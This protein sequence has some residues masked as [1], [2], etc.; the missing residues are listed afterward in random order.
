MI[1]RNEEKNLEECLAPVA[2]LF[3][4][5]V[6]IDTGSQDATKEIAAR[7]TQ[8]IFDFPWCDDFS[9]ARNES[10]ERSSGDWIFWLDADDRVRP[11]NA[12]RLEALLLSLEDRRRA[13]FMDTVVLGPY[14]SEAPQLLSHPRLF[15]RHPELRW[16]NRVH[17]QVRAEME[18]LGYEAVWSDIQIDHVGYED[19]LV[20]QR[21][22]KRDLRLLL[23]DYA[24]DPN[25]C[26]TVMHL[27]L[28]YAEIGNDAEARKHLGKLLEIDD[29]AWEGMERVYRVL[30]EIASTQGDFEEALRIL[31][32]GLAKLPGHEGLLYMQ[33]NVFIDLGR[34]GAAEDAFRQILSAPARQA[35]HG[36][37]S[38][39]KRKL[40][41][42]QLAGV[43][44]SQKRFDLAEGTL[45]RLVEEFPGDS[46]AWY[47]LGRV[48]ADTRQQGSFAAVVERLRPCAEGD[49]FAAALLAEWHL[50]QGDLDEAGGFIDEL[51]TRVPNA[52][53][54]REMRCHWLIMKGAPVEQRIQAYRDWVRVQ[55]GN[56][57][58]CSALKTLEKV[59]ASAGS[60]DP[61]TTGSGEPRTARR[62]AA[63]AAQEWCTSVVV[64][65]G[66]AG[67]VFT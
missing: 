18:K 24:T 17:E 59:R 5:I 38:E 2:R 4:E 22:A 33:A 47:E 63:V 3:D 66:M 13:Y 28:A 52:A 11:E 45:K 31:S 29:G 48:Y 62:A 9:A 54:P 32:G 1:V 58:A 7:Y 25:D 6:I 8:N 65:A 61:R 34:L 36:M 56:E 49:A 12:R 26:S 37:P 42:R 10:L 41:P 50:Q 60:G 67:A 16:R 53:L 35:H 57:A 14:K 43:F 15:R 21:K 44:R 30:A 51:I 19:P 27:G 39:I 64:D 20:R 23:M 46:Y 55:P 40:A